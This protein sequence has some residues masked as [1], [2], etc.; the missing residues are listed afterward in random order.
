MHGL[1]RE[2][3]VRS[4]MAAT[5]A[6]HRDR[7]SPGA[8]ARSAAGSG[9]L[10]LGRNRTPADAFGAV[11]QGGGR[12]PSFRSSAGSELTKPGPAWAEERVA[13]NVQSGEGQGRATEHASNMVDEAK[14]FTSALSD[15]VTD[16]SESIDLRGRVQR[17]PL[18][19]VG[20]AA[21]VGYVLGGG[22]FSP[23]TRRLL[24]V[25]I[26]AVVLP[27]VKR[28]LATMAGS[29]SPTTVHDRPPPPSF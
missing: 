8:T 9:P 27:F 1:M 3:C 22:L 26:V 10:A 14:A 16:F 6:L 13:N 17:A 25:G 18:A 7:A 11:Y 23:T 29:A 28:Q 21:G 19:M 15:S 24:K 20:A 12:V 4:P 2:L 5:A